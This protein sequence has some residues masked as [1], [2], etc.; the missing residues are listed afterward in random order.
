MSGQSW[1]QQGMEQIFVSV[2]CVVV[3]RGAQTDLFGGML[4][5]THELIVTLYLASE[6]AHRHLAMALSLSFSL[7]LSLSTHTH[8]HTHYA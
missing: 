4:Q 3:Q 5:W 2:A 1:W 8:T 6:D 7:S